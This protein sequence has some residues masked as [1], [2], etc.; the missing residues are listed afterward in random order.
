MPLPIRSLA[1]F[2]NLALGKWQNTLSGIDPNQNASLAKSLAMSAAAIG[3]SLQDAIQDAVAQAFPQTS[4]DGFLQLHGSYDNTVQ[5]PAVAAMGQ[6]AVNGALNTFVP[7]GTSL[8]YLAIIYKTTQDAL[9]QNFNG[10][11]GT[12]YSNGVVTATCA[13]PHYLATGISI[14]ISGCSQ[15]AFNGTFTITVLNETQF[16]YNVTPSNYVIDSGSYTTLMAVLNITASTQGQNTNAAAGSA[17]TIAV[18]GLNTSAFVVYG[19][20]SGGADA[21]TN[22]AYLSRVMLA[23]SLTPGIATA[24]QEIWSAKKVPGNTRIFVVPAQT[25]PNSGGTGTPG[26]SGYIPAVGETCLYVVRDNDANIA[27]N[28]TLLTQ[29]YNQIIADNLLPSFIPPSQLYVLA[30]ILLPINFRFTSITPNNS[31]M[32]AAIANQLVVFFQEN[33]SI[34]WSVTNF[35]ATGYYQAIIPYSALVSFLSN[36]QDPVTGAYLTAYT[37][38]SLNGNA[39]PYNIIPASGQLCVLGTIAWS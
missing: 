26:A 6:A 23:H 12:S 29:T 27:P 1:D 35:N 13:L 2:I 16:T 8:T 31:S 32:Q 14:T 37:L 22:A 19:G 18:A 9:V 21:E 3:Y 25:Q 15:S 36:L 38:A 34:Q 4:N 30:P 7:S 5:Y 11:F 39:T 20:I 28:N 24:P 17:L 33:A 10:T